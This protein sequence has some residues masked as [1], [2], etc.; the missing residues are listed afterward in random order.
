MV[1]TDTG[2]VLSFIYLLIYNLFGYLL[3]DVFCLC[4]RSICIYIDLDLYI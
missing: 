3:I 4:C 2:Y 1:F